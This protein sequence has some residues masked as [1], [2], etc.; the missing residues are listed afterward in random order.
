MSIRLGALT[1]FNML[2]TIA[3]APKTFLAT[4]D[5]DLHTIDELIKRRALQLKDVPLLG[6][7]KSGVVDYEEH[8]A[9][10]VDKYTDAAAEALQKRGIPKAV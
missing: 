8:S 5:S 10:A 6:Y 4:T 2:Q 7:P 1:Y 3:T 9:C